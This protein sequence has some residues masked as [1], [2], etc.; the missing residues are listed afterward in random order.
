M[1]IYLQGQ[2]GLFT[3]TCWTPSYVLGALIQPNDSLEKSIIQRS[4]VLG[5][6]LK[7]ECRHYLPSVWIAANEEYNEAHSAK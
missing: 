5:V 2:I 7:I 1:V 6:Y 4:R 3:L